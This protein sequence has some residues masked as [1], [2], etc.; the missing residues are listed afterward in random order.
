MELPRTSF[1]CLP[2]SAGPVDNINAATWPAEAEVY[3]PGCG[4]GFHP[5]GYAD[6]LRAVS[7]LVERA[8]D[9]LESN[10]QMPTV[11]SHVKGG[12]YF[13][14]L[15]VMVDVTPWVLGLGSEKSLHIVRELSALVTRE[16]DVGKQGAF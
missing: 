10:Q 3:L 7:L 2:D 13:N 16:I 6:A 1:R 12:E 11:Y 5:Y 4:K 14:E 9:M 15:S 8:L